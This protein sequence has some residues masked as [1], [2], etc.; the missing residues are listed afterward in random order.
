MGCYLLLANCCIFPSC[1]LL[2][3]TPLVQMDNSP[4]ASV[5][6]QAGGRCWGEPPHG[7]CKEWDP[8]PRLLH[9]SLQQL[10]AS[11]CLC[12]WR[13]ENT[14]IA[15]R[16]EL[17]LW[18]PGRQ[19]QWGGENPT[20]TYGCN[21]VIFFIASP[22]D[23]YGW[24]S[25]ETALSFPKAGVISLLVTNSQSYHCLWKLSRRKMNPPSMQWTVF[26]CGAVGSFSLCNSCVFR[27]KQTDDSANSLQ[28]PVTLQHITR[29]TLCLPQ[30]P[31]KPKSPPAEICLSYPRALHHFD[32][33]FVTI[34]DLKGQKVTK[35][36]NLKFLS[37]PSKE[38]GL[39]YLPS[40]KNKLWSN[41]YGLENKGNFISKQKEKWWNDCKIFLGSQLMSV[42]Y[43]LGKQINIIPPINN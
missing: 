12:V 36:H 27:Q 22:S 25:S 17:C 10:F 16:C 32:P 11:S 30:L 37:L 42:I 28:K 31:G 8:R 21:T 6:S 40:Y 3:F 4:T 34:I 9:Q 33:S 7:L 39:K 23:T 1:L 14:H 41:H 15:F 20:L 43:L 26:H 19:R 38:E 5:L 24:Q 29:F 2:S 18:E 13:V 35:S